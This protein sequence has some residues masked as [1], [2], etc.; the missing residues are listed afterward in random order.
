MRA[1]DVIERLQRKIADGSMSPDEPLFVLRAQDM[2]A[3]DRVREWVSVARKLGCPVEKYSEASEVADAMTR[4]PM[5]KVPGVMS[6]AR[7]YQILIAECGASDCQSAVLDFCREFS[8]PV[9]PRE[10]RFQGHLGF[11]GKLYFDGGKFRVGC[12][13]EDMTTMRSEIIDRA[14]ELLSKG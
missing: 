2:T 9:P 10:W 4:W 8:L 14:N 6:P 1:I 5:R 11:G 7:V 13:R 12:Y 3:A